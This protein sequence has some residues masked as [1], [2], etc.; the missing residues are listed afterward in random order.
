MTAIGGI[1]A[2]PARTQL[3]D[4]RHFREERLHGRSR[5]R[6]RT[7]GP[8]QRRRG[9]G[10]GIGV[11]RCQ[12]SLPA[13]VTLPSSG[14][15][16]SELD[17]V[18]PPTCPFLGLAGDSRSHYTYPHPGHR[19]FATGRPASA[20]A[21]RQ[22]TFCVTPGYAACDRYQARQRSD[23][24]TRSTGRGNF[25]GSPAEAGPPGPTV[26]A[27]VVHVFRAGD[28]LAR[29]AAKYDLTAEQ[30][31]GRNGLASDSSIAE[32]TRLVIPIGMPDKT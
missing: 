30:V 28:S 25:S 13:C 4:G 24:R 1:L 29:I 26:P 7:A 6:E 15:G 17:W 3:G 27:T 16:S 9:P 2:R 23:Q 31:A 22:T 18:D 12:S 11:K 10:D 21:R 32:G 14:M 20:D 8:A 19:C 5:G